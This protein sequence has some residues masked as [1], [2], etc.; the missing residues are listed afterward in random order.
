[1][2]TV[3]IVLIVV[4]VLGAC[5]QVSDS[6]MFE[7]VEQRVTQATFW[8]HE[9]QLTVFCE[10]GG[11]RVLKSQSVDAYYHLKVGDIVTADI[12]REKGTTYWRLRSW[13]N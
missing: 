5:G 4:L 3:L 9:S 6:G 10:V 1:M 13:D 11:Y 2:K 7:V 12:W 8:T